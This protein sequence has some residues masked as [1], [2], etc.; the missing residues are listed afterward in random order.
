MKKFVMPEIE[1]TRLDLNEV[2]TASNEA[3][4][5]AVAP[6]ETVPVTTVP[7][8]SAVPEVTDAGLDNEISAKQ[9]EF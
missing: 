2:L 4:T 8:T 9:W 6:T 3:E 5:S 7:E 1:I